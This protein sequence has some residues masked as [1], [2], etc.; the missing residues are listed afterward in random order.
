M[1]W[2]RPKQIEPVRRKNSKL[3]TFVALII[4]LAIGIAAWLFL[5]SQV[6]EDAN[7]EKQSRQIAEARHFIPKTTGELIP[8]NGVS[9]HFAKAFAAINE[10]AGVPVPIKMA[11]VPFV[12]PKVIIS[13]TLYKSG[14]EQQLSWIC[15]TE[16]GDM[17]LPFI[18]LDKDD[19]AD[20]VPALLAKNEILENE[21]EEHAAI[22]QNVAEA[23]RTMMDYL[24]QG[25]DPNEFLEYYHNQLM[26]DYDLRSEAISQACEINDKEPELCSDFITEVN[27]RLKEQNIKL[28][29]R[30]DI[31]GDPVDDPDN[32]E[33]E[34]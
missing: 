33:H 4:V 6:D 29:S 13:N 23:K 9:G 11:A 16:P 19:I 20:L 14:I 25:G 1:S 17:P 26:R 15:E 18:P 32:K 27:K 7:R 2:N 8:T 31:T 5:S 28:I 30:F 3:P 22:K 12:M 21:S 10:K 24:K 34:K